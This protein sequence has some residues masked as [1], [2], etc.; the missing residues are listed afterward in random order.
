MF[1]HKRYLN[2]DLLWSQNKL[3]NFGFIG[4]ASSTTWRMVPNASNLV[5]LNCC[6]SE[7]W[8]LTIHAFGKPSAFSLSLSLCLDMCVYIYIYI[9]VFIQGQC[10]I[11]SNCTRVGYYLICICCPWSGKHSLVNQDMLLGSLQMKWKCNPYLVTHLSLSMQVYECVLL[12]PSCFGE[13]V[14]M[15]L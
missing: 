2:V 14:K 7:E 1:F 15:Q 13:E 11:T 5:A 8:K 6:F 10:P 9:I 4:A 3:V 12:A